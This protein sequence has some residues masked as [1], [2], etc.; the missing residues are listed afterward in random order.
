M[1]IKIG[2]KVITTPISADA[3]RAQDTRPSLN[4]P[5]QQTPEVVKQQTK[6]SKFH[7]KDQIS[8]YLIKSDPNLKEWLI[9]TGDTV[10][11]DTLTGLMSV[12]TAANAYSIFIT[13]V[14]NVKNVVWSRALSIDGSY[15]EAVMTHWVLDVILNLSR[16]WTS[17][18]RHAGKSTLSSEQ[19]QEFSRL[20][21]E[22][23]RVIQT[24]ATLAG[25]SFIM[26]TNSVQ[27]TSLEELIIDGV[28]ATVSFPEVD[29]TED[30][31]ID[32]L[33]AAQAAA[34][35]PEDTPLPTIDPTMI[36]E[37]AEVGIVDKIKQV[38][39]AKIE[40]VKKAVVNS[41]FNFEITLPIWTAVAVLASAVAILFLVV[42]FRR[43]TTAVNLNGTDIMN[44]VKHGFEVV[45]SA[46]MTV[47]STIKGWF[48]SSTS[49]LVEQPAMEAFA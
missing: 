1:A 49:V 40:S 5:Q 34:A 28:S 39:S 46:V 42:F 43:S 29:L 23:H 41:R 32:M 10:C 17:V 12:R 22:T 38:I 31:K 13:S 33:R 25:K 20:I 24:E 30:E 6:T 27:V 19:Q 36:P 35:Q 48:S 3:V 44:A 45:K 9:Q 14:T 47:A 8:E 18:L 16:Y 4:R 11:E 7:H 15:D 2:D 26:T 21:D 37:V